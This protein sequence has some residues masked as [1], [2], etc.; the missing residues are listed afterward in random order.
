MRSLV[1]DFVSNLACGTSAG[2]GLCSH[3]AILISDFVEVDLT[4]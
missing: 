3:I 4:F 2:L 1:R